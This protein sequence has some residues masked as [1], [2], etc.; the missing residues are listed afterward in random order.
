MSL[1]FIV[2]AFT[3][4]APTAIFSTWAN[5]SF[6]N[7]FQDALLH[8]LIRFAGSAILGTATLVLT[9]EAQSPKEILEVVWDVAVPATL[10][11][12][13]NYCNSMAL[14]TAGITLTYVVKSCIPVF[15]VIVCTLQ[16]KRYPVII[17]LSFIHICGGVALACISSGSSAVEFS[18]FGLQCAFTSA[19]SQTMMNITIKEIRARRGYSGPKAFMGL[20]IWNTLLTLVVILSGVTALI[21]PKK[22]SLGTLSKA[23]T[24]MTSGVDS[25]P[26]L[27]VCLASLSFHFE[28]A[29]SFVLV[30]Y[31]NSVAFSVCDVSR[32]VFVIIIGA[33]I[34]SK[35]LTSANMVGIT[36][37]VCGVLWYSYLDNHYSSLQK[38]KDELNSG[39][40]KKLK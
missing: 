31:L 19:V 4:F 40:D 38:K 29:L 34:F 3:W 9:R 24:D 15:T 12:I 33:V 26:F 6:L 1:E 20:T 21:A 35:P 28:Y 2:V 25:W 11:W 17:Y 18:L 22:D 7:L 27:V 32:R 23:F 8:T 16:G 13:A 5:T 37:A 39:E 30:G 10:L 36:I 14:A